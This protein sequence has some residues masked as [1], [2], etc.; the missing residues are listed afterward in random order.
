MYSWKNAKKKKNHNKNIFKRF[1]C[2]CK[3]MKGTKYLFLE[4][5]WNKMSH[6]NYK[7][8]QKNKIDVNSILF[9]F[10]KI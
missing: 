10:L 5:H 3:E 1:L 4:D 7:T 6:M 8:F 9:V 2:N